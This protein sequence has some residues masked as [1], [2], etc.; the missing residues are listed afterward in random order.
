LAREALAEAERRG[1]AAVSIGATR[2]MASIPFGALAH[3]MGDDVDDSVGRL[4]FFRALSRRLA[5]AAAGRQL[6]LGVDDAHL[7]DEGTAALVLHLVATGTARVVVTVRTGETVPDAVTA[8]WKEGHVARID[9]TTLAESA[10]VTMAEA[11]LG[12]TLD[13]D[14][15][16]WLISRSAGSPL[17]VHELVAGAREGGA[18]LNDDGHWRLG[19]RPKLAPRLVDLVADHLRDLDAVEQRTM[20]A[21]AL[22]EPVGLA[23]LERMI[24][25]DGVVGLERRRLV[26]VTASGQ[27]LEARCAHPLYGEVVLAGLGEASGVALRADLAEALLGAETLK[28]SD[29]LRV[30]TWKLDAH[31]TADPKLL[32]DAAREAISRFDYGLAARLARAALAAGAGIRGAMTLSSAASGQRD[33]VQADAALEEWEGQARNEIEGAL[34][35]LH[36]SRTL[37][38]GLGRTADAHTLLD[39]AEQWFEAQA[40]GR[41]VSVLRTHYMRDEVRCAEAVALG[42]PL[43]DASDLG[44]ELRLVVAGEVA[45]ALVMMGRTREAQAITDGVIDAATRLATRT[46]GGAWAVIQAWE[47]ARLK[48]GRDWD[49]VETR[50]NGIESRT[51]DDSALSG[52]LAWAFGRVALHRG[53]AEWART[54]LSEAVLLFETAG[55][56]PP[57]LY[58]ALTELSQAEAMAGDHRAARQTRA[59]AHA[60]ESGQGWLAAEAAKAALADVWIAA[61]EGESAEAQAIAVT[62]AGEQGEN[63][64]GA[65]GLLYAAVL[66]GAQPEQ[67]GPLLTAIDSST[68][69]ELVHAEAAHVLALERHDGQ[70]LDAAGDSLER[71]G[72]ALAAAHAFAAAATAHQ[73]AGSSASAR[74]STARS[75]R[76][77]TACEGV[78]V[79]HLDLTD[80]PR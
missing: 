50:L 12:G 57:L 8:L 45:W 44:E 49:G 35:L 56:P 27:E 58:S 70:G 43:L 63:R 77:L 73:R 51:G 75:E 79:P 9:L 78:R 32:I 29:A 39:R 71:I 24:G 80:A 30:A 52:V 6:M 41:T 66:V 5:R 65:A 11:H 61:S 20:E 15:R 54:D 2:A 76:L 10:V 67:V 31:G 21:V 4:G 1:A 3:L 18:L 64:I 62:A 22:A 13:D 7:L 19:A 38:W 23:V 16:R 17:Y 28:R 40:W 36:R 48:G 60:L 72:A 47:E 14:A 74:T 34:Y 42:L 25:I 37:H 26:V 33:F 46:P 68:D 59:R 69:S 55:Y 53:H